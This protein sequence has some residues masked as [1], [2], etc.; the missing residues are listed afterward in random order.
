MLKAAATSA[1][2]ALDAEQQGEHQQRHGDEEAERLVERDGDGRD[3]DDQHR[4]RQVAPVDGGER[5]APRAREHDDERRQAIIRPAIS[6]G[7]MPA[8]G[9]D[10]VPNGR[11]PLSAST[12]EAERDERGAG[13]V[14]GAQVM[15]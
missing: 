11:S 14:I 3:R 15:G 4:V 12:S 10:S 1:L 5:R 13:D 7:I 9:D 8:P 2:A 6:F